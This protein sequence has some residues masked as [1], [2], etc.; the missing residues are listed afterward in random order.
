MCNGSRHA[1]V[2]RDLPRATRRPAASNA[3]CPQGWVLRAVLWHVTSERANVPKESPFPVDHEDHWRCRECEMKPSISTCDLICDLLY[4]E[5]TDS[6]AVNV[7][8]DA[9]SGGHTSRSFRN[10]VHTTGRR[11]GVLTALTIRSFRRRLMNSTV[12]IRKG[13]KQWRWSTWVPCFLRSRV[14]R[15][16]WR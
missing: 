4:P 5:V 10:Y 1:R 12:L 8:G 15:E 2:S 6:H 16:P 11:T 3:G 9:A 7:A 14:Q 13:P